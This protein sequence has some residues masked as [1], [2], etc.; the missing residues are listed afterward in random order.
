MS[1]TLA[2]LVSL[3]LLMFFAYRGVTV[4]LLAPLM[5]DICIEYELA[6]GRIDLS[7]GWEGDASDVVG[8]ACGLVKRFI[9]TA[10]VVLP[11]FRAELC[12]DHC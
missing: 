12:A 7:F 4:L 9:N 5:G 11:V 1:G 2:I 8:K 3:V 10:R 6:D